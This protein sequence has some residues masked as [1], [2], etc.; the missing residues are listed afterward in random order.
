MKSQKKERYKSDELYSLKTRVRSYLNMTLRKKNY[1]KNKSTLEY[2]CCDWETFKKHIESQFVEGMNWHNRD[3][4]QLD[5]IIPTSSA[6]D[7]QELLKLFH[8]KNLQPMWED[9]NL[10]KRDHYD[11][12]DKEEYLEWYSKNVI[13]K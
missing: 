9:E 5:H 13:K 1:L 8:Y 10:A 11:P 4:W 12:K 6:I 3:K 7:K 2:L